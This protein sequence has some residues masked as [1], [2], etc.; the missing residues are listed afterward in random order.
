MNSPA[1]K[2]TAI[3]LIAA[4]A[5]LGL[6]ACGGSPA[7][8]PEPASTAK[9]VTETP[10]ASGPVDSFVWAVPSEPASMD[11]IYN[12][13]NS[14]GQIMAN[15]CDGL[16]RL[17]ANM[18]P[19]PSLAESVDVPD[20][21]TRIYTLQPDAKFHDGS[22][23]TA[24]DVVFSLKRNMDPQ[25]GSYWSGPFEKVASITATGPLEVTVKLTEPDGLLDSYLSSPAGIIESEQSFKKAGKSYGTPQGGVNCIGPFSLDKWDAGQSITL[26]RDPNYYDENYRALAETAEFQFVRDPAAITNGLLA[27]SIDGTWELPPAAIDK[28]SQSSVGTVYQGPS[29]QGYNAIVMDTDGPLGDPIVRQALSRAIDREAII[30]VAISG[31]ADEQRAPAVPGTW[32]YEREEF[33]KAW[34]AI[35]VGQTDLEAAKKLLETTT[36][37]SEPIVIAS[38][39][40]EAQTPTIAAEI[41]SAAKK[42]GLEAEIKSIP[43]DQYYAVY[44]DK[45]ARKGIDLYLTGWGTDFADPTQ[46][47][48]YFTTGNI[49][50]F[51]ELSDPKIDSLVAEAAATDDLA[52]RAESII[53][54]QSLIVDQSLWLP[55][56]APRNLLFMNKRITGS[57]ASYVQLHYPWAAKIG[58]AS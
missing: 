37:P 45:S 47:Y 52:H 25:A 48:Q 5:V 19:V 21:K 41:Q 2:R 12:A 33:Q 34:D 27:G 6:A 3:G 42:I 20:P 56:Y 55:I 4:S 58:A 38:T 13:D 46:I 18:A 15:V 14:T 11:W 49:Y 9:L 7:P 28:L 36:K 39:T 1:I 35:E 54:A 43:A 57:P 10:K 50:N 40:A 26:K 23:L 32:S 24:D 51:T 22:P 53:E 30:K 8:K 29:T 31:A 44:T 16:F 17:D